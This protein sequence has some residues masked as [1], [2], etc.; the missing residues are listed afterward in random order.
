MVADW[1]I[2]L[3]AWTF[4][5]IPLIL[6]GLSLWLYHRGKDQ[7]REEGLSPRPGLFNFS[8]IILL[9]ALCSSIHMLA[10]HFF[11]IRVTQHILLI[12]V[13]ISSF[14]NSDPFGVMYWGV[15]QSIQPIIDKMT[16]RIYPWMERYLTKGT[17][18]FIFILSVWVW[19]DFNLVDASLTRP[20]LRHLENGAMIF[21]AMLHWWHVSAATPKIHPRLPSFAHMG[22]TLAGAGPLKIP[23]L[24]FLFSITVMYGY[25]VATFLGWELEPLASQRIG[26]IIIWMVGGTVYTINTARHFGNWLDGESAKPPRPLSDWDTEEVFKAPHLE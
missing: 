13:F 12:S 1:N 24:F 22:Y 7:A 2:L 23:G 6:I 9:I 11:F 25:P 16:E 5:P 8:Q 21:G 20:W 14:M 19:Y 26:G 17:C 15:P 4:R 3:T 18:W 10:S